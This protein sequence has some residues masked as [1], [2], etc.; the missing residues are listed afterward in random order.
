MLGG[1]VMNFRYM[2]IKLIAGFIMLI[3]Y[4]KVSGRS[5]LAPLTASDQVGNM[6]IGAL[7]STAIISPDVSILEAIILVFMWAGLQI[8]VRFIKFRSSDAAE[9]FDGSP[10]LLIEN[11][12]LQKDGFLKA[13]ISI[14]DFETHIHE[15]GVKS[16]SEVKNA[17]LETSGVISLDKKGEKTQSNV[18]IYDGNI[19]DDTLEE[20]EIDKE[21]LIDILKSKGYDYDKILCAELYNKV[22]IVY[23][24]KG[25][26]VIDIKEYF[27]I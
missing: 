12:V 19:F 16:I 6:V 3:V 27:N 20:L 1:N 13:Q 15:K 4:L 25:Q 9:F 8:L 10:I 11:G 22:L 17:W 7:V 26:D 18:I 24:E 2:L 23:S 21:K 14:L 5:Q